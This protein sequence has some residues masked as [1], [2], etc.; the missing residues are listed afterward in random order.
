MAQHFRLSAAARTISLGQVLRMVDAEVETTFAPAIWWQLLHKSVNPLGIPEQG[1]AQ[2]ADL[3]QLVP[4]AA[5]ASEAGHLHAENDADTAQ[6]DL[7][8]EALEPQASLR[9]CPRVPLVLV[10][11]QNTFPRPPQGY[12]VIA[13]GVLQAG[14]LLVRSEEHTSELQSPV[15]LVCR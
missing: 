4:V 6:A 11:H 13:Q 7:G 5:R 14:G 10:Y 15:H 9:R 1:I 12:R 3:E 8:H 2:G